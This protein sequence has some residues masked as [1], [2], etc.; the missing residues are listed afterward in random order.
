MVFLKQH[1]AVTKVILIKIIYTALVHSFGMMVKYIKVISINQQWM[2]KVEYIT[3]QTN[4]LK[5][6]GNATITKRYCK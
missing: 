3:P 5:V 1:K 2:D 6:N 4:V